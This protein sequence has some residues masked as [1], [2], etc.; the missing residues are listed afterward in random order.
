MAVSCFLSLPWLSTRFRLNHNLNFV[1]SVTLLASDGVIS[2]NLRRFCLSKAKCIDYPRGEVVS[3]RSR[4]CV[5][6]A[7]SESLRNFA[8]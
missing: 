2:Y 7:S 8:W 3:N 5:W 1:F 6:V 4:H